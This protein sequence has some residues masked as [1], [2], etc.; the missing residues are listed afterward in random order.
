MDDHS[1][2]AKRKSGSLG[3]V[4]PHY[5]GHVG[6]MGAWGQ[7]LPFACSAWAM[8]RLTRETESPS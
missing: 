6:G 8:R 1:F 5:G 4:G 2:I 3:G 7:A